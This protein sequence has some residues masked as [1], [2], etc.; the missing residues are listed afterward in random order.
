LAHYSGTLLE[1]AR[2][3]EALQWALR[4]QEV[5]AEDIRSRIVALR[6]LGAAYEA[7][8]KATAALEVITKARDIALSTELTSERPATNTLAGKLGADEVS[9]HG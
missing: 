7:T 8:G 4:A 1:A 9:E 2:P 5:P 3:E 6:A